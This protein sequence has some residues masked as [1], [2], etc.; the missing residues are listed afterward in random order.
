M[1]R[2]LFAVAV[3]A[4]SLAQA[5]VVGKWTGSVASGPIGSGG[6]AIIKGTSPTLTIMIEKNGSY[7]FSSPGPGGKTNSIK[8]TWKQSGS[9][10]IFTPS[11]ESKKAS[12]TAKEQ[13]MKL[14]ADKKKLIWEVKAKV[15]SG[16]PGSIEKLSKEERDKLMK[17]AKEVTRVIEFKKA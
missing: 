3:L 6:K 17:D 5:D 8:G 4:A 10:I 12:P 15:I 13:K 1:R 9:D 11:A 16:G 2:F 14:S 7:T